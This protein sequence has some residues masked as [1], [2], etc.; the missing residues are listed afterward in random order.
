MIPCSNTAAIA[1]RFRA[2]RHASAIFLAFAT[3]IIMMLPGLVHAAEPEAAKPRIQKKFPFLIIVQDSAQRHIYPPGE[4][5][6]VSVLPIMAAGSDLS[7]NIASVTVAPETAPVSAHGF[8]RA[9]E[10]LFDGKESY[11]SELGI[12]ADFFKT[13]EPQRAVVLTVKL[14]HPSTCFYLSLV[15]F[16]MNGEYNVKS[17]DAVFTQ[18][19]GKKT[20]AQFST[21]SEG[22]TWR[23]VL[24]RADL[25]PVEAITIRAATTYKINITEL[26]LSGRIVTGEPNAFSAYEWKDVA[27][28]ASWRNADGSR[29]G[30]AVPLALNQMTKIPSPPSPQAG[31][32]GLTIDIQQADVP[33]YHKEYGFGVIA[34]PAKQTLNP[35]SIFG[36]VH[37]DLSDPYLQPSWIKTLTCDNGYDQ[38]TEKLNVPQWQSAIESRQSQGYCELPI[39]LGA[40]WKSDAT[41]PVSSEQLRKLGVQMAQI[42]RATPGVLYYELGLEENLPYRRNR[43]TQKYFWSNLEAKAKVVRSAAAEVN[44]AIK[45]IYQI[46]EF[47]DRSIQEF[48]SNSA[49]R[50]FDIIALHPYAW[51]TFPMPDVWLRNFV[52]K[53]RAAMP[54][55]HPLAIWFTEIG[56]AHH[57]NPGGFF[58]YPNIGAYDNGLSRK[59]YAAFVVRCHVL[60]AA[61]GVE[62]VFWYNY[63]DSA[64]D[65]YY[66]ERHFGLV[67]T[68]GF[69]KPGYVAYA[70]MVHMMRN[71]TFVRC[72][73]SNGIVRAMFQGSQD[74]LCVAW[75]ADSRARSMPAS[76]LQGSIR[77][78]RTLYGAE[79]A[80]KDQN[81]TMSENPLF[82]VLSK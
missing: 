34:R 81:I 3:F 65:P 2:A 40:T 76:A 33:I 75:S 49:A 63:K 74:N 19:D 23:A 29:V 42:F 4:N 8:D 72:D 71:R 44:P 70:N 69:P 10:L 22:N 15:G 41:Q 31:Y 47:D 7:D 17:V 25:H 50:Q 52:D 66:A 38:K 73:E 64:D 55:D 82:I 20:T 30:N 11:G 35:G 56:A 12:G 18:T 45:L 61:A 36:M 14:K 54:A 9:V 67:D 79:I 43:D 58:G 60:A 13:P 1:R 6:S 39:A 32:Y 51:A 5:F 24:G 78:I 80:Y 27:V 28:E 16:N 21:L 46:A 53:T 57:G 26:K 68:W 48:L 62:K 37:H 77:E 59:D